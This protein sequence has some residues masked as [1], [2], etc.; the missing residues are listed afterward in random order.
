MHGLVYIKFYRHVIHDFELC[1]YMR[2]RVYA[3]ACV[4]VRVYV[5]VF[6]ITTFYS[7]AESLDHFCI[8]YWQLAKK[9]V[10]KTHHAP[11]EE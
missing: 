10:V 7:Q 9:R 11:Q 6:S 8:R 1:V 3:C 2:A 5:C 4:C